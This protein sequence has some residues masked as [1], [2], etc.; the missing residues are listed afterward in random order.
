M[1]GDYII[2][3]KH[4]EIRQ[5]PEQ[6]LGYCEVTDEIVGIIVREGRADKDVLV[7]VR[8]PWDD[9]SVPLFILL[10]GRYVPPLR[11]KIPLSEIKEIYRE[12]K[13]D[14]RYAVAEKILGRKILATEKI[15]E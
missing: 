5:M 1:I 11:V 15:N 14:W 12:N 7:E 10:D 13:A 6:M 2:F 3:T 4:K 9:I 8:Y